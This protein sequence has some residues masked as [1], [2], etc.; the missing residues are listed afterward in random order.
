[1][2]GTSSPASRQP[3]PQRKQYRGQRRECQW[4]CTRGRGWSL[5]PWSNTISGRL[6]PRA[7][8]EYRNS[9]QATGKFYQLDV[10]G[11]EDESLVFLH[12]ARAAAGTGIL[13]HRAAGSTPSGFD[14]HGPSFRKHRRQ[15]G[16]LFSLRRFAPGTSG[17]CA[18]EP[19]CSHPIHTTPVRWSR[20][21]TADRPGLQ[22]LPWS[23]SNGG[24]LSRS[25]SS[26]RV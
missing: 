1:M 10:S 6:E 22:S 17:P 15:D 12:N 7:G 3:A 16:N 4:G 23:M 11:S 20:R 24:P 19:D 21:P 5:A 26:G 8:P 25:Q 13:R 2:P 18:G 9:F 14:R